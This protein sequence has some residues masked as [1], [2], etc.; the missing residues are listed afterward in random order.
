MVVLLEDR[1]GAN[2]V[3]Q[4]VRDAEQKSTPLLVSVVNLGEVFYLSWMRGN[5]EIARKA[6]SY[7][8]QLP[9]QVLPVDEPQALKA[10]EIRA[11][12]H[13][14]YVDCLA[15]ALSSIHG[16]T[17]VTSDNDFEKLGRH[18]PILWLER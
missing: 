7:L 17:L 12:H 1:P 18:F 11:L 16:A 5:E 10:G 8:S 2:R 3:W 6:V 15:A 14:P 4:L 13:V 9:I